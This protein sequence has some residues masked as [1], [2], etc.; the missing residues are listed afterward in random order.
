MVILQPAPQ[1]HW[2]VCDNPDC[3][4]PAPE[5]D[6]VRLEWCIFA[7]EMLLPLVQGPRFENHSTRETVL[8]MESCSSSLFSQAAS[9]WAWC[10]RLS[11]LP[12]F[13]SSFSPFRMASEVGV[14]VRL[15]RQAKVGVGLC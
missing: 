3:Q 12:G 11:A 9:L 1:T 14:A 4:A 10:G 13:K 15:P 7:K 2:R 6:L 5:S 8:A